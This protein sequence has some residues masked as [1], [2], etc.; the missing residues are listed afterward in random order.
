MGEN[1]KEVIASNY[2]FRGCLSSEQMALSIYSASQFLV[3]EGVGERHPICA[4]CKLN[5]LRSVY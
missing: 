2:L 3:L 4:K 5:Q 1:T